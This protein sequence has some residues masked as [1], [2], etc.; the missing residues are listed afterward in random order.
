MNDILIEKK[1]KFYIY[2]LLLFFL[3]YLFYKSNNFISYPYEIENL[4]N[5][6]YLFEGLQTFELFKTSSLIT[7]LIFFKI[8]AEIS[9]DFIVSIFV[10]EN[11]IFNSF[12]I[13]SNKVFSKN[14][15]NLN[16]NRIYLFS[17]HFVFLIFFFYKSF[18]LTLK[19]SDQNNY[20][21]YFLSYFLSLPFFLIYISNS[22]YQFLGIIFLLLSFMQLKNSTDDTKEIFKSSFLL[23]CSAASSLLV[24]PFVFSQIIYVNSIHRLK[25]ITSFFIFLLILSPWLISEFQFFL[26]NIPE[27]FSNVAFYYFIFDIEYFSII[28]NLILLFFL[29][30]KYL[31]NEFLNKKIY[32][33]FFNFLYLIFFL[34]FDEKLFIL[35]LVCCFNISLIIM[36]FEK[37]FKNTNKLFKKILISYILFNFFL[38]FFLIDFNNGEKDIIDYIDSNIYGKNILKT[39][40]IIEIKNTNSFNYIISNTKNKTYENLYFNKLLFS[41]SIRKKID[42]NN[43]RYDYVSLNNLNKN[44]NIF[45]ILDNYENLESYLSKSHKINYIIVNSEFDISKFADSLKYEYSSG[46]L[47]L[48]SYLN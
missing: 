41:E 37:F 28:L 47:F 44:N 43:R 33:I 11:S 14:Y 3:I 15:Q 19:V 13:S 23:A 24:I 18:L 26:S 36:N 8:L 17:I 34:C 7:W 9:F 31:S 29:I 20:K 22:S 5:G 42:L 38:L 4:I 40:S 39:K 16:F 6:V 45:Y 10:N 12:Y 35:S 30:F 46:N 25:Y 1:Y 32:F 2:F 48:Y 27:Y 21:F